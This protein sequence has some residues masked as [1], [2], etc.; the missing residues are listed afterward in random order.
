M[1][2]KAIV[3][4]TTHYNDAQLIAEISTVLGKAMPE[5]E[6]AIYLKMRG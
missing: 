6:I 4:A 5:L 2:A 3:E 1:V